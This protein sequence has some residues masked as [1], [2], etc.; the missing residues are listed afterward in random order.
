M[1]AVAPLL[2]SSMLQPLLLVHS[3]LEEYLDFQ[4]CVKFIEL[5][6][7]LKPTITLSL[8]PDE[9]GPPEFLRRSIHDFLRKAL[10]LSHEATKLVWRVVSP[11]A[12]DLEVDEIDPHAFGHHH[13]QSFLN[14]GIPLGI[15][16][17]SSFFFFLIRILIHSA[18]AFYHFIPPIKHCLDP[19]CTMKRKS[20][21]KGRL[22]RRELA[23]GLT[24]Q[25]TVFTQDFGPIPGLSTSL[26]CRG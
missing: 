25:V 7:I 18:A 22:V 4:G 13:L 26:Y 16:Q 5:V 21:A 23:E 14:Y 12:W 8:L 15:C 20:A 2:E 19:G 6:H 3:E 11:L 9:A 1:P 10:D 17:S 24:I